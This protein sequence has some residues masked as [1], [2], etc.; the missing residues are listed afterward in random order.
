MTPQNLGKLFSLL[1]FQAELGLALVMAPNILRTT[2]DHLVTVFTNSSFESRFVLQLLE[3]LKP[4]EVDPEYIPIHG[5]AVR[6]SE[7]I[8]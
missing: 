3:N 4:E 8:I 2:S 1:P 7:G 6:M 5:P